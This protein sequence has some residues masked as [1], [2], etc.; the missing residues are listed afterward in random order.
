VRIP[1]HLK[2]RNAY[3]SDSDSDSSADAIFSVECPVAAGAS[4]NEFDVTSQTSDAAVETGY[5][6]SPSYISS[7]K[8][9]AGDPSIELD[10]GFKPNCVHRAVQNNLAMTAAAL[11]NR[12]NTAHGQGIDSRTSK[13][14]IHK[15]GLVVSSAITADNQTI[16]TS[17]PTRSLSHIA[18]PTL[19]EAEE[20]LEQYLIT[21]F[22][23]RSPW[24]LDIAMQEELYTRTSS[25]RPTVPRK[26][27]KRQSRIAFDSHR[28]SLNPHGQ[29]PIQL[30]CIRARARQEGLKV[31]IP[32]ATK[33]TT[34]DL[35]LSSTLSSPNDPKQ[36]IAPSVA[37]KVISSVFWN[38]NALNDLFAAAI[39]NRTF[40]LASK[41]Y[42]LNLIKST[43][44]NILPLA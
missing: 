35:V 30:N 20:G 14:I 11:R 43:L 10:V 40:Y 12:S 5:R 31:E 38:L 33:R 29:V 15:S 18:S 27:S 26:S 32:G 44:R 39:V 2:L 16:S 25:L 41:R 23:Y 34:H 19:S 21:A 3:D 1:M 7:Q 36:T 24:E 22:T 4:D 8:G 6:P 42:E 28:L 37:K 17:T 9:F 13:H